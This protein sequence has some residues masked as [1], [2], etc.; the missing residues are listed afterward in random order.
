MIKTKKITLDSDG[1]FST[2]VITDQVQQLVTESGC[3]EGAVI[4]FFQHTTG[5]VMLIEHEAGILVDLEDVL[6]RIAPAKGEYNHHLVGYDFNGG[7]HI[8][9]A[10]LNSSITVPFED[11]K[12]LLGTYQDIMVLDMQ[13][14]RSPRKIILQVSGE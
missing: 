8:R 13:L 6:E 11:G 9:N 14:E 1:G 10:L 3:Q 12:L 5:A 4:V 7:M 2:F